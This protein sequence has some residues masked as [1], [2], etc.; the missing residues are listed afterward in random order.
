MR[1]CVDVDGRLRI[2]PSVMDDGSAKFHLYQI[3]VKS[4]KSIKSNFCKG[5]DSCSVQRLSAAEL[6][7]SHEYMC[8]LLPSYVDVI[9][10][11]G[12]RRQK[13]GV[14]IT[15]VQHDRAC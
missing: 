5:S 6:R 12:L 3:K 10:E 1:S 9:D 7:Q 8:L 15:T 4:T 2:E 13:H 14:R 11:F